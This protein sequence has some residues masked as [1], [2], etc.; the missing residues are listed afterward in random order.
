MEMEE[1]F[2]SRRKEELRYHLFRQPSHR[3]FGLVS[4]AFAIFAIYFSA[5]SFPQDPREALAGFGLS[6]LC[7]GMGD[8]FGSV[9]ELVPEEQTT[10]AGI[11]RTWAGLF[12]V[13]GIVPMAVRMLA[14]GGALGP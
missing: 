3:R 9:A 10:L 11:L 8:L 2:F 5:S 14:R 13:C 12:V 7:E 4:L 1:G 6:G